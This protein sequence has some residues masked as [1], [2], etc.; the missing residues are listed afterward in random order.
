[1]RIAIL[2]NA[3]PF[4]QGG[5]EQ[6]AASLV[7]KLR[8]YGHQSTLVRIPFRWD[9]PERI[10]EEIVASRLFRLPN[11]DRVIGLKFPAYYV[12]H[13]D[14]VIWLLHQFRQAY[15]FW[16]KQHPSLPDCPAARQIR[17]VIVAADNAYLPEARKLYTNSDVT[18]N[19]LRRFNGIESEV[20][21]PPLLSDTVF[22][23][24]HCG[25]Y[26]LCLGRINA[27]KRQHL[28]VEA[29]KHCR[30]AVKLVV[31]GRAESEADIELIET[32]IR[33]DNLGWR[34]TF[35]NRF[36]SDEEKIQLLSRALACAYIPYDED[37]YG[38]VSLEACLSR[39]AVITCSDSGGIVTL[40]RHGESGYIL[41]PEP[42]ALAAEM[43]SLYSDRATA[44]RF[45]DRGYELAQALNIS[46]EHVIKVL[47]S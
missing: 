4:L 25:D 17:D 43:D 40:V 7:V 21:L 26:V 46:W 19:R 33:Q 15:D 28:M 44:Q 24:E 12:R 23:F 45:G 38:Y 13:N 42:Q 18:G 8:E 37:S 34:V 1:M 30:T 47:T 39:K 41:P 10:V 32:I 14:K 6:L 36:I 22:R 5:A 35:I 2:N 29:L 9:P 20:L 11:V 16:G 27:T 31:A 3:V